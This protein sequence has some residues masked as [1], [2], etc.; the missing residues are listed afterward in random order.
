[1]KKILIILLVAMQLNASEKP[2]EKH[3]GAGC[4]VGYNAAD[5]LGKDLKETAAKLGDIAKDVAATATPI[6]TLTAASVVTTSENIAK[7]ADSIAQAA[8]KIV[9]ASRE[10]GM[11]ILKTA[12]IYGAGAAVVIGGGYYVYNRF[13]SPTP[14]EVAAAE[15]AK[16]EEAKIR[17]ENEH[18]QCLANNTCALRNSS[19]IPVACEKTAIAYAVHSG[20]DELDKTTKSFVHSTAM[21]SAA[22]QTSSVSLTPS[23]G[24]VGYISFSPGLAQRLRS[25][26]SITF[27]FMQNKK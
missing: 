25:A 15:Q 17:A 20:K 23:K 14:Q 21:T 2:K 24:S 7:A 19:G 12:G 3:N 6:A 18:K 10:L 11:E 9:T 4:D 8:D 16:K 26:K 5:K 1:M 22:T 27:S 13:R